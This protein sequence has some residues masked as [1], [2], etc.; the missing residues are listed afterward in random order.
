MH[1]M[2]L[3]CVFDAESTVYEEEGVPWP[4]VNVPGNDEVLSLLEDPP[5]GLLPLLEDQSAL[6]TPSDSAFCTALLQA[7]ARSQSS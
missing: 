1:S 6:Q 7:H 2:R 3:R 5:I 4:D